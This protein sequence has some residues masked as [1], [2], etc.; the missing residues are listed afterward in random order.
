VRFSVIGA[1]CNAFFVRRR[2]AF[3]PESGEQKIRWRPFEAIKK[4][5]TSFPFARSG[6]GATPAYVSLT[7]AD[8]NKVTPTCVFLSLFPHYVQD[9]RKPLAV[10]L[11]CG[12]A[13]HRIDYS[14]EMLDA[15][16]QRD[17]C[18]I[19]A[20]QPKAWVFGERAQE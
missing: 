6:G 3:L 12:F 20:A 9:S 8:R 14:S 17:G 1:F 11:S 16:A 13:L 5:I 10:V 18:E 4:Y 19:S 7:L 15:P 2:D